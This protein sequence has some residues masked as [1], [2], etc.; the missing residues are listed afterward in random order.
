[1]TAR[2][3]VPDG[4]EFIVRRSLMH[5]RRPARLP[6]LRKLVQT[7]VKR[8]RVEHEIVLTVFQLQG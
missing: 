8:E 7:A 4:L 3:T 5:V 2:G 6:R 1:M